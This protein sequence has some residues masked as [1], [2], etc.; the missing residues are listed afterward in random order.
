MEP[1][2][3]GR[4]TVGVL[5][6]AT[7]TDDNNKKHGLIMVESRWENR[8]A[9]DGAR[10]KGMAPSLLKKNRGPKNQGDAIGKSKRLSRREIL[11]WFLSES[12]ERRTRATD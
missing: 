8:P 11:E 4:R 10:H 6:V 3:E 9:F 1:G 2:K 5:D 7:G 12:A